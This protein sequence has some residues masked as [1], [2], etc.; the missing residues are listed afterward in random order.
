MPV[1][2]TA[3]AEPAQSRPQAA[4]RVCCRM[5]TEGGKIHLQSELVPCFDFACCLSQPRIL[6]GLTPSTASGRAGCPRCRKGC[7][8]RQPAA[9][10][11]VLPRSA[12]QDATASR[13]GAGT[14][15]HHLA[16]PARLRGTLGGPRREGRWLTGRWVRVCRWVLWAT[17]G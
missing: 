17:P 5:L 3:S 13:P 6:S 9:W 8:P 16:H 15:L 12:P 14:S 2:V 11:G 7:L 4:A 1:A 10:P